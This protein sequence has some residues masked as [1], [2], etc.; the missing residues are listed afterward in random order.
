[1]TRYE[2]LIESIK[3]TNQFIVWM[4]LFALTALIAYR[5][6]DWTPTWLRRPVKYLYLATMLGISIFIT[7]YSAGQW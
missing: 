6:L 3:S 1:M 7:V 4:F 5:V 2:L